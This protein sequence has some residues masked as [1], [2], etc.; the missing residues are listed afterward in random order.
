MTQFWKNYLMDNLEK[1]LSLPH[2]TQ[3]LEFKENKLDSDMVGRY[4][5]ALA[6]GACLSNEESGWLLLGIT[7]S[8]H[9]IVG[10]HKR[11]ELLKQGN[12]NIELHLRTNMEP[13]IELQLFEIVIN[14]KQFSSC[15]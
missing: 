2:E 1:L 15:V 14:K 13:S 4:A 5:S 11:W 10:T 9:Q 8:L 6:N 12:Q 7:D 3:W